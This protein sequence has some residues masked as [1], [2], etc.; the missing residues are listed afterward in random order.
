[1][2]WI[3]DIIAAR[4]LEAIGDILMGVALLVVT[5]LLGWLVVAG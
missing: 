5:V 1:M 4:D 2:Y 3:L